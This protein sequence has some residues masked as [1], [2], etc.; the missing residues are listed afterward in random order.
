MSGGRVSGRVVYGGQADVVVQLEQSVRI[1]ADVVI[2]NNFV[3]FRLVSG[4]VLAMSFF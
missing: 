1:A 4:F 2:N 3:A